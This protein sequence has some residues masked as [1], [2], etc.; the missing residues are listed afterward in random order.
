M[1]FMGKIL[2]A[3]LMMNQCITSRK[4]NI[5]IIQMSTFVGFQLARDAPVLLFRATEVSSTSQLYPAI[6][7]SSTSRSSRRKNTPTLRVITLREGRILPHFHRL[8]IKQVGAVPRQ[9]SVGATRNASSRSRQ[10]HCIRITATSGEPSTR[11]PLG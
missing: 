3:L 11:F 10:T 2:A 6:K 8:P 9:T 4:K 5:K 1:N 7:N